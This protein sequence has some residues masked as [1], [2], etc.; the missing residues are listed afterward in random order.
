MVRPPADLLSACDFP[1]IDASIGGVIVRLADIVTCDRARA[2]ALLQWYDDLEKRT[3]SE[4][5]GVEHV[6]SADSSR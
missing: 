2:A 5:L 4:Q 6:V 1:K 3:A